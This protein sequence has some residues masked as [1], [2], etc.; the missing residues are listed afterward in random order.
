MMNI[1]WITNIPFPATSR[2]LGIP[3]EIG[4]GWMHSLAM[5]LIIGDGINL[6][7]ATTYNGND[8]RE[9]TDENFLYYIIPRGRANTKYDRSL[10]FYWVKIV[11]EFKPDVI[12]IHGTEYPHGLA[13]MKACQDQRYIISI[14]GM[15]SVY[16]E[17]H[18]AGIKP[19]E[20]FKHTT[21]NDLR[22]LDTVT[23]SRK[24]LVRRAKFELDYLKRTKHVIGRT[25]WDYC[26]TKAINPLAEY[27]FCNEVLR[28]SF[29]N[30]PRWN[31]ESKRNYSIFMS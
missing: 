4:G 29:Y 6:A 28:S 22:R 12:H 18:Y 10:E 14:Q 23:Q 21:L 26:H 15:L 19:S 3:A 31:I 1:L 2:L 27:H 9:H 30:S 5:Q 7:I 20:F 25:S 8:M 16:S 13:C 11:G 17:Y 24:K